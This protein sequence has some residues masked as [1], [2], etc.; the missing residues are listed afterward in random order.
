MAVAV[1]VTGIL[2]GM[3]GTVLSLLLHMIQHL[4]YGY[5]QPGG[6][7]TFVQGVSAAPA[8]RRVA[9]L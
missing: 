4:A 7:H 5:G 1:V 6:P 9:A 3:G 8:W 2:S